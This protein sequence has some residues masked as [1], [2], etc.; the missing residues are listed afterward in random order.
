M[1][2]ACER[3]GQHGHASRDQERNRLKRMAHNVFWLGIRFRLLVKEFYSGH[4]LSLLRNLDAITHQY[5]S[6]IHSQ[7]AWKDAQN[8]F[9][10]KW[11]HSLEFDSSTMKRVQQAIV[12]L[13]F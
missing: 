6:A 9:C 4:L 8:D 13:L 11:C 10:P 5:D 3:H 7:D 2:P 12:T 1:D